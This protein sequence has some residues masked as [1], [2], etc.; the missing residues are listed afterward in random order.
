MFKLTSSTLVTAFFLASAMASPFTLN[1]RTTSACAGFGPDAMDNVKGN[2]IMVAD[3][4]STGRINSLALDN[5][6][7]SSAI[8]VLGPMS[9]H[10]NVRFATSFELQDGTLVPVGASAGAVARPV[11]AGSLVTF[12]NERSRP[13]PIYC[14]VPQHDDHNTVLLAVNGDTESFAVCPEEGKSTTKTNLVYQ[15]QANGAGYI[16]G[17]CQRV[18]VRVVALSS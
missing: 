14:A 2:F 12:V 10:P 13:A 1:T 15:P 5:S 17:Q 6:S 8:K 16:Y 7:I 3:D 9:T 11:D 18:N 4:G